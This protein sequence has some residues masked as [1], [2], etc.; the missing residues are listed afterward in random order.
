MHI[1]T[2]GPVNADAAVDSARDMGYEVIPFHMFREWG[3]PRVLEHIHDQVGDKPVF[4]CYDM[5]FFDPAMVP[6]V[7]T[8]T[9]GGA[10][11]EEGINLIRGLKGLNV[12]AIDINTLT[13]V[14]D[15]S[16]S[17]AGL[18]AALVAEGLGILAG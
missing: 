9:P 4:V 18:A 8:P 17:S 14:H 15:P 5:D 13:P 11:P 7:A 6:G 3:I 10:L 1:G 12:I 16:G 2:R